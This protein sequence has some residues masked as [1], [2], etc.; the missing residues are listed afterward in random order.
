MRSFMLEQD[1]AHRT[2]EIAPVRGEGMLVV[3]FDISFLGGL[4]VFQCLRRFLVIVEWG[5]ESRFHADVQFLHFRGIQAEILPTERT[6]ADQFHLA[7]E[8]IDKHGQLVDPGFPEQTSP[9]IHPVVIGEL[10]TLL[11]TLMLQHIGLEVFRIAV[12][13]PELIDADH[14]PLIPNAVQFHKHSAGGFVIPDGSLHLLA[15]QVILPVVETLVNHLESG[16][17]HPSQQFNAAVSPVLPIRHPHIEPTGP[18]HLGKRAMPQIM[19]SVQEFTQESGE[20]TFDHRPLQTGSPGMA[21]EIPLVHQHLTRLVQERIQVP[22][23]V[24]ETLPHALSARL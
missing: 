1:V 7:L 22:D 16:P 13:R 6:Y 2:P 4:H 17:I 11:Q 9:E 21:A 15:Q 12:H 10:A 3:G 8:D 24:P 23:L 18:P 19:Q 20:R 14:L 5:Q